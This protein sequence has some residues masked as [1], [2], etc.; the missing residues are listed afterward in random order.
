MATINL[1]ITRDDVVSINVQ[2]NDAGLIMIWSV[3]SVSI[4]KAILYTLDQRLGW[5]RIE[6]DQISKSDIATA[7]H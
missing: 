5:S 7:E 2:G 4:Y 1:N 6:I 3:R